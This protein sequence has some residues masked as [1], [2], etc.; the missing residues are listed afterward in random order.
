[1]ALWNTLECSAV[2]F[3]KEQ[4]PQVKGLED[5]A[6]VPKV[7]PGSIQV[8]HVNGNHWLTVSTLDPSVDVTHL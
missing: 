7:L 2:F 5:T 1:M 4:F 6:L 8:L 3:L